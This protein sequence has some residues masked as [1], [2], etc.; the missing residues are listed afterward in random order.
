MARKKKETDGG[1]A[2]LS[3]A[4]ATMK[5]KHVLFKI[6]GTSPLLQNNPADFIGKKVG[7]T[8]EPP[9]VYDDEE[10]AERR[11]YKDSQG[12]CC[13]PSLALLRSM[14]RAVTGKKFGK[15]AATSVLRGTVFVVEPFTVIED[16]KGKP[17]TKYTIDRQSV[18]IGTARILRCRPCWT[19]WYMRA[20]LEV[21]TAI[22]SP[23]NVEEALMLAGRTVGIGDFR[24][25]KGGGFGRFT[26]KIIK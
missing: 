12:R 23:A 22:I 3:G 13:H 17:A 14:I 26:A 9:K 4:P 16:A 15:V 18:V 7:G 21:D 25:E 19:E 11:L 24:P 20:V 1:E 5:P 6:T 8:L 10:E 2:G